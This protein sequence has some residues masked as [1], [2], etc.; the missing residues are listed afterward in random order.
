M[1]DFRCAPRDLNPDQDPW[2]GLFWPENR[3]K[4]ML[5]DDTEMTE[6]TVISFKCGQ[7][8]GTGER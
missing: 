2:L 8:V 3:G 6:I 4:S 7:D 1:S 5:L